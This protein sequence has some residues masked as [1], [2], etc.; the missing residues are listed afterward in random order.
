[1]HITVYKLFSVLLYNLNFIILKCCLASG[2]LI[3]SITSQNK[4]AR[5]IDFGTRVDF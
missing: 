3:L 4:L 5:E 2:G 1:M